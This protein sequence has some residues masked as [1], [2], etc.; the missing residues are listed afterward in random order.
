LEGGVVAA[1]EPEEKEKEVAEAAEEVVE[2]QE[3]VVEEVPV[4]VEEEVKQEAVLESQEEDV[5]DAQEGTE[6]GVQKQVPRFELPADMCPPRGPEYPMTLVG[7]TPAPDVSEN[8]ENE[9]KVDDSSATGQEEPAG[10]CELDTDQEADDALPAPTSTFLPGPFVTERTTVR[11]FETVTQTVRVSVVTQTETVSTVV[12]A[13]PQT[14]EETV[15]ET[16]TVRITVSVPVEEQQKKTK[17][18]PTKGC[19]EKAGWF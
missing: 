17:A 15:Y 7:E 6:P 2:Q 18:K 5:V 16:E 11:V 3:A 4:A 10:E 8:L 14:V 12:T 13:I 1:A 19:Q 9:A